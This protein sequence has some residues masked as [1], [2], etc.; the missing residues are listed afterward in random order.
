MQL[1][2]ELA[3]RH[4]M[5]LLL[6]T[7]VLLACGAG[8][9]GNIPALI[10]ASGLGAI[11]TLPVCARTPSSAFSPSFALVPGGVVHPPAAPIAV[12]TLLRRWRKNWARTETPII[13]HLAADSEAGLIACASAL[14]ESPDVAALEWR[15]DGLPP[16]QAAEAV[17]RLR[18]S[19]EKP[20]LI[21]VPLFGA[22]PYCEALSEHADAFVVGAPPEGTAWL[23]EA[24]RWVHGEV[25]GVGT[26]PLVLKALHDL[27][28]TPSPLIALGGI[29]T[30]AQAVQAILAGAAAIMLDT[31]VVRTP[32]LPGN[33]LQAIIIEMENRALDDLRDLIG[34]ELR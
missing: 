29:H 22:R 12:R 25:H 18:A 32:D 30:P 1:S 13:V 27:A 23:P 24:G 6:R 10:D 15:A 20:L 11:V 8:G 2:V 14:E 17:A 5:G 26:F 28:D 19:T 31:A 16:A 33:A 3:P 4:K 7:P 21:Q 9:Y 34:R